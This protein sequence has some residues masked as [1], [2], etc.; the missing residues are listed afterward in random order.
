[1]F[2]ADF[3]LAPYSVL[4]C[5]V[6]TSPQRVEFPFSL[7]NSPTHTFPHLSPTLNQI[8]P[9]WLLTDS[10]Y[11]LQ[12]N[13]QKYQRRNQA[14]RSTIEFRILRPELLDLVRESCRRLEAVPA[15][16]AV[17]TERDIPGL[18]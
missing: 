6:T 4:A 11:T 12:R 8:I 17:Y 9:A 18:G 13:E 5:S 2:P 15:Q 1:R 7:I 10:L 16:K 14:R 3:T